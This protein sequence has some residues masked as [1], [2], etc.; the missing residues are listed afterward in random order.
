MIKRIVIKMYEDKLFSIM[1]T[2]GYERIYTEKDDVCEALKEILK[3]DK[4]R[5]ASEGH[6]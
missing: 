1:D 5:P 2:K 6:G 4:W 3:N